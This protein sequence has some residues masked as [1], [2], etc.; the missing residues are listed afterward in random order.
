MK[1][2]L[3]FGFMLVVLVTGIWIGA[4]DYHKVALSWAAGKE[5]ERYSFDLA[6]PLNAQ[7]NPSQWFRDPFQPADFNITV[8][9]TNR[10]Q[11]MKRIMRRFSNRCEKINA[12]TPQEENTIKTK[13]HI[14]KHELGLACPAEVDITD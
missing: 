4:N 10:I 6:V 1:R 5:Y 7:G 2:I 14:C 8:G 11:A 12:G 13:Y 9:T 3:V